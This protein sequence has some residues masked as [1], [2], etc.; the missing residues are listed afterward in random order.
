MIKDIEAFWKEIDKVRQEKGLNWRALVGGNSKSASEYKM[1]ISLRRLL[2]LQETLNVSI[3]NILP[4]DTFEPAGKV[5]KNPATTNK[6]E[7][8]YKLTRSDNWME[9]EKTVQKV[10]AIGR[11]IE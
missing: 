6:M 4:Y 1:N 2:E 10:Q 9:D 11:T 7:Q 3:L 8:I 5:S